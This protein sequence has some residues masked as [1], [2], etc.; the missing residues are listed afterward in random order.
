MIAMYS[1]LSYRSDCA[2]VAVCRKVVGD[3]VERLSSDERKDTDV[4]ER[5]IKSYCRDMRER[6]PDG[7]ERKLVRNVASNRSDDNV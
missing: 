2:W 5:E 3:V 4:I 6:K 7:K 1:S